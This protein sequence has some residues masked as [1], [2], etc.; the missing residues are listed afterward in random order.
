LIY[1]ADFLNDSVTIIDGDFLGAH[2]VTCAPSR[3]APLQ[4]H[5]VPFGRNF[6]KER[7]RILNYYWSEKRLIRRL[8]L[9]P[10]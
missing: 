3:P 10:A 1:V 4:P 9:W 5:L 7:L 8:I 6:C 2:A